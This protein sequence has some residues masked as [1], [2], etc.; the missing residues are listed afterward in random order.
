M[1]FGT[2]II[3]AKAAQRN[4][5]RK[6]QT[7][8]I[9]AAV[10]GWNARDAL[11]NMPETDAVS[12]INW[13]PKPS[14]CELRKGYANW[15]TDIPAAAQV[16]SLYLYSGSSDKLFAWAGTATYDVTLQGAVGA[17]VQ[18]ALSNAR[19]IATNFTSTGG[20]KYLV[21]VNGLD[22]MRVYDGAVWATITAVSAPIAITG[23]VT[24]QISFVINHKSRLWFIQAGTLN[25]YYMPTGALGGAASLFPLASVFRKGGSLVA[26]E[27]WSVDGGYGMDDQL[28]FISSL[29]EIAVYHGTDPSTAAT[30][31]LVGV[32]EFNAPIG[33]RPTYK[34]GG[35]VL[36]LD[37]DGLEPLSQS[38]ESS[39]V[40]TASTL[41]D[42]IQDAM[43]DAVN[44]AAS[45]YGWQMI[46]SPV[47]NAL[48]LN[49]PIAGSTPSWEQY[50]M[51]TITGAWTRFQG[52]QSACW[53]TFKGTQF[54]GGP[55]YVAQA[56]V[57]HDDGGNS[58]ST[59]YLPAFNFFDNEASLKQWVMARP[60]LASD[61]TPAIAYGLNVD[62][63]TL[64]VTGVPTFV[65]N[66]AAVW[67]VS[68]WD[69]GIWSGLVVQKSWQFVAGLG[70]WAAF[71][72]KSTSK[73]LQLQISSIDYLYKPAGI[74]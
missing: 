45:S 1:G 59:D 32:Y 33:F 34:W 6:G 52:W 24:S 71:R 2:G 13:F 49:V 37:Y 38:L 27:T 36:I 9:P 4:R 48:V 64:D 28:I 55:G 16:E 69:S 12:L 70:Y 39:R 44:S 3:S 53:E 26:M 17:A 51:N 42:K 5:G 54:F 18:S 73:G 65:F 50:V 22:S 11:A 57:G 61:G 30:W 10:G 46:T 8:S 23:L 74:L 29:G 56:W 14:R 60:I 66:N 40:N 20:V 43:S 15:A 21:T 67:D 7:K 31:S 58:I 47:E 25:A 62:F 68:L 63:E 41:T 35:D 72:M 19:W